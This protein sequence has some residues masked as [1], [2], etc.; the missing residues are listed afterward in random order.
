MNSS[1]EPPSPSD[2]PASITGSGLALAKAPE[3]TDR[4]SRPPLFADYQLLS[5]KPIGEGS[6]GTVYRAKDRSTD[7]EVA[8]KVF[9]EQSRFDHSMR[10]EVDKQ[11]EAHRSVS[12]FISIKKCC[13]D[14]TPPYYVMPFYKEG[15]LQ[16]RIARKPMA[17]GEAVRMFETIVKSMASLH[18]KGLIH[19]DLKPANILQNDSGEPLISDFGLAQIW[20]SRA[21]AFG[22]RYYM[23][24][25]QAET[26]TTRGDLRWDVYALGATLYEMLSGEM[27]RQNTR[28]QNLLSHTG[29][30]EEIARV[31]R[32]EIE[33][34]PLVPLRKKL[35][36][37]DKA[38]SRIVDRCL[39]IDPEKRPRDAGDLLAQLNARDRWLRMRPQLVLLTLFTA[40]V[41]IFS[42]AAAFTYEDR[43][44]RRSTDQAKLAAKNSLRNRAWIGSQLLREKLNDRVR[45]VDDLAAEESEKKELRKPFREIE[46]QYE[47]HPFQETF[48]PFS[49][50]E[51][52]RLKPFADWMGQA[53]LKAEH[54]LPGPESK[55]MFL[56]VVARGKCFLT[57]GIKT[58]AEN[59]DREV[60][61]WPPSENPSIYM[62]NFSW[63]DY[64]QGGGNKY[65]EKNLPHWPVGRTH[66]SQVTIS[67][68]ENRVKIIVSTPIRYKDADSKIVGLLAYN[69]DVDRD[70]MRWLDPEKSTDSS[71]EE[72]IL[73]NERGCW[74]SHDGVPRPDLQNRD[75][76]P[77]YRDFDWFKNGAGEFFEY[78]DPMIPSDD[79]T[80]KKCWA[81]A[82]SIPLDYGEVA[83]HRGQNWMIVAQVREKD[84]L[85]PIKDLQANFRWI[86]G[87]VLLV[88][89]G[90]VI[91]LWI[92]LIRILLRQ[93]REA[94]V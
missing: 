33:R 14:A 18:Q 77:L 75:P 93:G 73:I 88:F 19:G 32:E 1:V 42:L 56:M 67:K 78:D 11:L 41:L 37:I 47:Q 49:P 79:P 81:Y 82:Q 21:G 70:L 89:L 48:Q 72:M 8:I 66:I 83:A 74:V 23:P 76:E 53:H 10:Q 30:S 84:G 25:E 3:K 68:P 7:E 40:F 35:P 4:P 55:K 92:A 94:H 31:Y 51:V 38:L 39:A 50:K 63:R 62:Q 15:S 34:T 59:P 52:E 80:D 71:K 24:P 28:L 26:G 5:S 9:S 65:D 87:I 64:F 86:G 44:I 57:A 58:S 13:F 90:T 61:D 43:F 69:I 27:P 60:I 2:N 46:E 36:D 6:R 17:L 16:S 12:G 22:T 29:S 91:V 54:R 45:L 20:K 85:R